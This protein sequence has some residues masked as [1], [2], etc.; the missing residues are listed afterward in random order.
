MHTRPRRRLG[1]L[2]LATIVTAATL[3]VAT[4]PAHAVVTVTQ[5]SWGISAGAAPRAIT[6]GPDGN[7]WFT[8]RDGRVGRI[9]A[10]GVITEFSAGITPGRRLRGIAAGP[11]GNV[12]F[13]EHHDGGDG[14]GR[15]TPE[16]VVTEFTAGITPGASPS[17]IA[18]G[19]DGNLWFT[20]DADRIGR[21]T[22]AG[23]VTEFTAGITAGSVPSGI[24]AGPDG[25]LWFTELAGRIGRITPAGVVTQFST[26][27]SA[28]SQLVDITSGPD[29]NLWFTAFAGSIGRITPAGVVT[30]FT[31]GITGAG[32]LRGIAVGADGNLWFT[33]QFGN[34]IGRITTDGVVTGYG[35]GIAADAQP[36]DVVAG[37]DATM[38]FTEGNLPQVARLAGVNGSAPTL[39]A[40]GSTVPRNAYLQVSGGGCP[41][42]TT[43]TVQYL[44]RHGQPEQSLLATDGAAAVAPDGSFTS[45]YFVDPANAGLSVGATISAIANC[46]APGS[47]PASVPVSVTVAAAVPGSA[48]HSVVPARLLDSRTA[49]GGWNG[50]LAAATPRALTVA[51][52]GDIPANAT[53]VVMNITATGSSSGSFVTAY[54][55]GAPLPNASNLNFGAG[56]TIPNLVTVKVGAGGK[57]M[58]ANAVGAV[59]LVA[60]VV[61][62]Y[63]DGSIPGELFSGVSPARILDSRT[64]VGGWGAKLGA[65]EAKA[66]ALQV[67][68]VA[69]VPTSATT[70][71]MNVTVTD[72]DAGSFLQVWPTGAPRPNSSNLNFAAGETI[73]NLVT[74]KLGTGGKVSVLNAVGNVHVIAD[75]VGYFDPSGGAR[76]H[77]LGSP[78]RILDGRVGT[79]LTGRWGPAQSR[80]L[81]ITGVNGLPPSASA[82]VMNTTVT[83]GT[84]GSFVTVY[85]GSGAPPTASNLNF[86][87]GQTIPNLVVARVAG[88]GTVSI[89]NKLGSVDVIADAVGYYSAL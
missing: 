69:G 14:I 80:P 44:L 34:R 60:D 73:P 10:S 53:A 35:T 58:F 55:A 56:Q 84:E 16:G 6:A 38:W 76:F 59:D 46:G 66:K 25:N 22:P 61:G 28:G 24:V 11:D 2:A 83:G 21:I 13:T 86:G 85:P 43:A 27:I 19:P 52:V 57:V 42:S 77:A 39:V 5:F 37:P 3:A 9:T 40:A 23:V 32:G 29:G 45:R 48:F 33:E 1:A 71:V 82:L 26:G 54:P 49:V 78:T 87:P 8:E 81:Q 68:G 88:D 79:G 47:A 63:D 12:W 75:V 51:G 62:Y 67:A 65:G 17:E 30:E 15:I 70:V 4:V 72:G 18:A 41:G 36:H 89:A 7:L 64:S 50:K 20:M 31:A 74:V